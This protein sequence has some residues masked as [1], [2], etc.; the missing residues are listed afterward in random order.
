MSKNVLS[1]VLAAIILLVAL[2]L[3]FRSENKS[4][5]IP[6]PATDGKIVNAQA[7]NAP[8]LPVAGEPPVLNAAATTPANSVV[9]NQVS[10]VST[11]APVPPED[12][13]SAK[14]KLG[15]LAYSTNADAIPQIISYLTNS[16]LEV[17]ALAVETIKQAGNHGTV[18]LLEKMAAE[19]EDQTLQAQLKQ[20]ALF[21]SI[22]SL[23]ER[24]DILPDNNRTTPV[25]PDYNPR[26]APR[27]PVPSPQDDSGGM[28]P[29]Q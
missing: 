24:M 21:L 26:P 22:P 16:D 23:N 28:K 9:S 15:D 1:S 13:M 11:N 19:T 20:A 5:T 14:I 6:G 7:V 4:Q 10:S 3:Y 27:P 18:P 2:W 12:A 25:P 8:G 17:R 29:P